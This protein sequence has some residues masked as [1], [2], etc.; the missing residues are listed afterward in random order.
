MCLLAEEQKERRDLL[1]WRRVEDNLK[2]KTNIF[3]FSLLCLGRD[4]TEDHCL[5]VRLKIVSVSL[6]RMEHVGRQEGGTFI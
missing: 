6:L 2:G 5:Q 3:E 1:K 4:E